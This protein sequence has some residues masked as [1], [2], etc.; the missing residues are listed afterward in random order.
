VVE[1]EELIGAERELGVRFPL[2]VGELNL[3]GAI[4][5]LHNGSDLAAQETVSG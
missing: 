4:Q 3:I 5:E 1:H 2:V